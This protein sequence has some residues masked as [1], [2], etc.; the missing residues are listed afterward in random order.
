MD[1]NKKVLIMQS[2]E[3]ALEQSI[4]SQFGEMKENAHITLFFLRKILQDKG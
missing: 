2:S 4:A 1:R 3:Q